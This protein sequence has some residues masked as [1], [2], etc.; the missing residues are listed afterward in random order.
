MRPPWNKSDTH[1]V[2][3]SGSDTNAGNTTGAEASQTMSCESQTETDASANS[4][5][6]KCDKQ[7][8][9]NSSPNIQSSPTIEPPLKLPN[10]YLIK[11][12]LL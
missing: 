1:T 3:C 6:I 7:S 11:I 12:I 5:N 8:Q 4:S 10:R 2:T 9:E